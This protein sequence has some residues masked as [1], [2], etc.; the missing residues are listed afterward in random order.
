MKKIPVLFLVII[1]LSL[2]AVPS[3][4][5]EEK[6]NG[7]LK[8]LKH[9]REKPLATSP[10]REMLGALQDEKAVVTVKFDH[11]LTPAEIEEYES[12]G[13]SF[14]YLEGEVAR[15][16]A[17]YP[18]R[19]PWSEIDYISDRVE[20]LRMEGSWKPAVFPTLDVSAHEIEADSVW[21]Y[22][23][24]LG[25]PLTGQGMR[26]ADFDTGIDV[27][28]PSFFYAD[29]DTL[30]WLDNNDNGQFDSGTDAVDINGN[31]IF[32]SIERLRFFDGWIYDPALQWGSGYPSNN[33]G[34]YQTYWD[35][36]YADQNNNSTRDFG[37]GAGYIES[38]PTYGEPLY[39]VLDGNGNGEL[40]VGEK[41]VAL[42]TSKIYA[43]MN[44]SS[45]ERLR[46]TDLILT[47]DDTNG[48]GTSVSGIL[49]GGTI[50]SHRF[51]GI[52]PDAEILA[53]AYFS[54]NPISYLIPWARSHDVDAVLYEFGGFVWD[55]LD[56]SSLEEE[57]ITIE[58]R[59]IIQITPSGNLARGDKH[60][61]GTVSAADSIVLQIN[62]PTY[63]SDILR[64]YCTTLWLH[65]LSDLSF[66]LKSPLGGQ[67]NL[68]NGDLFMDGYYIWCDLS[69]SSR[70]TNRI[71]VYVDRYTN[72]HAMGSWELSVIN[73]SLD[74]IEII[75]NVA[76]HLSSWA[77]GAEFLN[78]VS[79]DRNV[80]WPAT[81]DSALV[82][83]SYSTR[84]YEGYGGVGGG[85]IP[86]GEISAFS[87]R[88]ARIDGWHLVDICSP[89]NYD[90]W[91][92]RS[93]TDSGAY[94]LGGYRQFSGT[95]AAG[96]HVAAGAALVQQAFPFAT[97]AEVEY[98]LTS[99]AATDG[100]TGTVYNDTWGY[101]KLR[102][103]E[104][105]GCATAVE[106]MAQGMI[107]PRLLLD[108]NYPNPFNPTTWI[109]FY[110]PQDGPASIK[111]YNV[112]GRLVRVLRDRWYS[113]GAHSVRWDGRDAKGN[114]V[115]SGLYLCVL[116]QEGERQT[117]KL[118]LMR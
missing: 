52:A 44:A 1:I 86:V 91:S 48:H 83:G 4:G 53:G 64:F 18:L 100:F 87:G 38:I 31:G 114:N 17:I 59:T 73:N 35:W 9:L 27:F 76:D 34:V 24:P 62:V 96:P 93:H 66:R 23:D 84:G 106:E 54:D 39:I 81:T 43:T 47:D 16:E 85:S 71:D 45:T 70:S 58:N 69:T 40:N 92:P 79:H 80:T 32:D 49:A 15:T 20:V 61:I 60:A 13:I 94:P 98:L 12:R 7:S 113:R 75:S 11:V 42:G 104:A 46:G 55:Y 65:N 97:M 29:G 5:G 74:S 51:T 10:G 72:S 33:D 95:S 117:R 99:H 115:A 56:G 110:L 101:G 111:I 108:Q 103:M 8:F 67:I 19:V 105:M 68:A 6:L 14:Y 118:V 30:D 88:G 50:G 109:P 22:T 28:H 25:L 21:K 26:I 63:G 36:L 57:L 37:P 89:G 112:R 82:N 102:L 78:Y 2:A 41:L 90:V 3:R 107:T 116:T 77:G